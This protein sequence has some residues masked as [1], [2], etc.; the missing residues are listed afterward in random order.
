MLKFYNKHGMVAVKIY[1]HFSFG[2]G[3]WLEKFISFITQKRNLAK[4]FF[5]KVFSILLNN[6][7]YDKTME[8]IRNRKQL[9]FIR[10]DDNEEKFKQQSRLTFS[11]IHKAFT[12]YDSCTFN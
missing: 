8:N 4:N 2:Q 3:K 6:A 11:G 7:S 9:E 10:K 1:E 5:E 12:N